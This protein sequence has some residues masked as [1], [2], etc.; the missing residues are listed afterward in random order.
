MQ[1]R[2]RI[3]LRKR[4]GAVSTSIQE[5]YIR[6][7]IPCGSDA[8]PHCRRTAPSLA[9]PGPA[10]YYVLPDAATLRDCLDC[11]ET[12]DLTDSLVILSS[13]V[14]SL[15]D[16]NLRRTARLRA[17]CRDRRRRCILFDDPHHCGTA[18]G[19]DALA[20]AE[21]YYAHLARTPAVVVVSDALAQA[22]GAATPRRTS[23][24][25]T[26]TR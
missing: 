10:A 14:R 21:W 11:L 15:G 7:D 23:S 20:V 17:L 12:P 2:R 5:A 16:A 3:Q 9:P 4:S 22:L 25:R 1:T 24:T 19:G 18:P 13:A 8:C 6:D 26:L